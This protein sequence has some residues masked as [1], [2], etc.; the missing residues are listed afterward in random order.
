MVGPI[1][2][3]LLSSSTMGNSFKGA[4]L[5]Y[6]LRDGQYAGLILF[7]GVSMALAIP[8][9]LYPFVKRAKGDDGVPDRREREEL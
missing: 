2:S 9:C 7:T 4:A 3:K 1:S 8:V 6:G 5:A